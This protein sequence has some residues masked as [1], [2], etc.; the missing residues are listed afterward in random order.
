MTARVFLPA[1]LSGVLLWTAFFP[2]DLG[3][4]AVVA[5]VLHDLSSRRKVLAVTLLGGVLLIGSRMVALFSISHS[6]AGLS[7]IRALM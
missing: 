4:V 1:I 5:L 3:P 7:F 2:L 6:E